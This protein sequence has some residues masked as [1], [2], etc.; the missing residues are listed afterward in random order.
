MEGIELLQSETKGLQQD[1][2]PQQG[3]IMQHKRKILSF[4]LVVVIVLL[5]LLDAWYGLAHKSNLGVYSA[6]LSLESDANSDAKLTLLGTMSSRSYLSTMSVD[7]SYCNLQYSEFAGEG[8]TSSWRGLGGIR[9]SVTE[10]S[11]SDFTMT[12]SLQ[13]IAYSHL[14]HLISATYWRSESGAAIQCHAG[15]TVYLYHIIPIHLYTD[16]KA[17]ALTSPLGVTTVRY[18]STGV[19]DS[20]AFKFSNEFVINSGDDDSN[21]IGTA[22]LLQA[23]KKLTSS[24]DKNSF[25][26]MI[27]SHNEVMH[28]KFDNPLL[29]AKA[30]FALPSSFTLNIPE[31]SV[32]ATLLGEV[33]HVGRYH[34]ISA[35]LQLQL[36]LPE[37]EFDLTF[38][39]LCSDTFDPTDATTVV[40]H[41]CNLFH[42][43]G[44][45]AL[46]NSLRDGTLNIAL[47]SASPRNFLTELTGSHHTADIKTLSMAVVEARINERLAPTNG[48]PSEAIS[49]NT[50]LSTSVTGVQDPRISTGGRCIAG[51]A[52]HIYDSYSCAVVEKGFF[53]MYQY[54]FDEAGF[55]TKV[56]FLA[57]WAPSA[58]FAA[59]TEV[60]VLTR[61]GY[62]TEV[63]STISELFQNATLSVHTV[64]KNKTRLRSETAV[65]WDFAHP[66][67]EGY[68]DIISYV[69]AG[70]DRADFVAG[71]QYG[72]YAYSTHVDFAYNNS[73]NV[74]LFTS[75]AA[76]A[77]GVYDLDETNKW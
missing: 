38:S 59:A 56:E 54:I 27:D 2:M 16:L 64:N 5:S 55:L 34:F 24:F 63:N 19:S 66:L 76:D 52:D 36:A 62:A 35:P 23:L 13:E 73:N 26:N 7:D 18:S 10:T 53:K 41:A 40:L 3:F 50:M 67:R 70:V 20:N 46:W 1:T 6:N 57:S 11:S 21:S 14:R 72:D 69:E 32:A 58:P 17:T 4:G 28:I 48:D 43:D 39:L 65:K 12:L 68:V 45:K 9:G 31:L 30:G 61:N 22:P 60:V 25:F 77:H 29:Q 75:L 37:I 15:V 51:I 42:A 33:E 8:G 49:F 74:E 71:C 44:S 47:D